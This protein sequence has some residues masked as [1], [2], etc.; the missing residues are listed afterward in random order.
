MRII[1]GTSNPGLAQ[2]IAD[3]LNIPL[4]ETEISAFANGEKRVWIKE[5]LD[6]QDVVVV[7]SFS[8]PVDEHIIEF[9]LMLD[10]LE[11]LGARDVHVVIPWLG[12]SLQDKV[13][14]PGEPIAAKVIAK[15]ISHA[16]VK[17]VYLI[18]VHNTSIPGFFDVPC[19]HLSAI[20]LFAQNVRDRFDTANIVIASPDFGGLKR[21]RQFAAL[22]DVPLVNIDKHRDLKTGAVT[23]VGLH[24]KVSDKTVILFDDVILSGGTVTEASDIL[25]EEGAKETHFF[26]THGLFTGQALANLEK[27][28]I[29]SVTITNTISHSKLPS[30]VQIL[31]LSLMLGKTLEEWF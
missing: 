19:S 5:K 8:D 13:F 18:D 9:L 7:Q 27:S 15:L 31:D 23:A 29:D 3:Q 14:R 11:R 6:G 2:K 26:S 25:K 12:Y 17:R 10:A 21:A 28:S 30:K 16:Y 20:D 4:V 1:S 24:G 22:F